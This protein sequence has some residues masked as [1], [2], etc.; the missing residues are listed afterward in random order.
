MPGKDS[1]SRSIRRPPPP[2]GWAASPKPSCG[3]ITDA[4]PGAE[5]FVGLKRGVTREQFERQMA[6][7]AVTECLHRVRVQ[8]GDAMFLPSGRVHAIGGGLVIFEIQQNSDTTYRVFDWNRLGLDG[9]PRQ[10]HVAESLASIDFEDF[11]PALVPRQWQEGQGPLK[12]RLLVNHPLFKVDAFLVALA[13]SMTLSQPR[14]QIIGLVEGR[15]TVTDGA[16]VV[17]LSPG[18]FCLIPAGIKA[19]ARFAPATTFLLIQAGE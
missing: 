11:E 3:Y 4:A 9:K 8:P 13:E 10:L 19:E 2:R 14:M 7:G 17:E 5:L 18:R 6:G 15:A 12:S 16:Q 1:P